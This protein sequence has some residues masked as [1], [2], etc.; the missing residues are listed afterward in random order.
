MTTTE[1]PLPLRERKKLRTRQAL[2]E[3]AVAMFTERGFDSTTLDELVEAVEVSKRTF[4]RNFAS[5]ED[6]ATTAVKQL[7]DTVLE[8]VAERPSP[9]L[10][11]L[12]DALLTAIDR[13]DDYW[14]RQFLPAVRLVETHP[15]LQGYSLRYCTGIQEEMVRLLPG[16]PT[17]ERRLLVEIAVGAWHV[18]LAEWSPSGDRER[19]PVLVERAFAAI[20]A[21]VSLE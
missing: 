4:F 10:D 11:G 17:L 7:W 18:A 6:V 19:L 15:A 9:R 16:E 1:E 8:V 5:K 21:V 20:P 14:Y 3:T 13:M 12:K 2:A